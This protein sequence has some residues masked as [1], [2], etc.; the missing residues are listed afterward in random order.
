MQVNKNASRENQSQH[1]QDYVLGTSVY[2]YNDKT[3]FNCSDVGL[4]AREVNNKMFIDTETSL[5]RGEI[6]QPIIQ[7]VGPAAH[8]GNASFNMQNDVGVKKDIGISTR[9]KRPDNVLSGITIDRF[10]PLTQDQIEDMTRH[11]P[12]LINFGV[13]TR[14]QIKYANSPDC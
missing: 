6:S 4:Y 13:D 12:R 14:N 8:Y 11:E 9:V 2:M 5:I 7:E 10:E 1:V 3:P